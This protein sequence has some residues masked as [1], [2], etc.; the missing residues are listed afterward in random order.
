MI[1]YKDIIDAQRY[2]V[3]H[4]G[5]AG[6]KVIETSFRVSHFNGSFD[7]FLKRCKPCGCNWNKMLLIGIKDL[8]P[9]VWE[10]IPEDMGDQGFGC[11]CYTLLLCGVDTT[12]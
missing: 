3:D 10:E 6:E 11:I 7:N 9:E 12:S 8:W 5:R 2:L 4:W 1:K